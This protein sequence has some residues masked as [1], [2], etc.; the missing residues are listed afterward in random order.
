MV[1]LTGHSGIG[2]SLTCLALAGLLPN[3]LKASGQ[4]TLLGVDTLR[5]ADRAMREIRGKRVGLV[6]QDA[7]PTLDPHRTCGA[8]LCD[9]LR[10]HG[11]GARNGRIHQ[12]DAALGAL[13][14]MDPARIRA[15][16]PHQLSGGEQQRVA[17]VRSA[18][19]RPDL[20]I[21]DEVT[22]SLD[23]VARNALLSVTDALRFEHNVAVLLITHDPI[24]A[25]AADTVVAM[26][27]PKIQS[28]REKPIRAIHARHPILRLT[29]VRK[30]FGD[31]PTRTVALDDVSLTLHRGEAVGLAGP[32]GS[33]KSTLARIACGLLRADN[34]RVE[35]PVRPKIQMIFQSSM[36]AFDP[37]M[38]LQDS[39]YEALQAAG[40]VV[41]ERARRAAKLMEDVGLDSELL[42]RL[43]DEVSG[44]QRQR[45]AVARALA[46]EPQVIIADE[47][48]SALDADAADQVIR[49][50]ATVCSSSGIALLVIS[51]D[52]A[53]LRQLCQRT[54]TLSDGRIG[55]G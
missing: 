2:K 35:A 16:F 9:I 26:G 47:P 1:A 36:A 42:M 31:G 22:A 17:F 52:L 19:P 40:V 28:V 24:L 15:S 45:V 20:L 41:G 37:L 39:L 34:G 38:S 18:I 51:H 3:G 29:N 8:Q 48:T 30:I 13:G 5:A 7:G 12:I 4:A 50:L 10:L 27:A 6:F 23:G 32:S 54:I 49:L 21:L 14:F 43:P 11:I 46:A 25:R 44:G 55:G 53:V 33:G